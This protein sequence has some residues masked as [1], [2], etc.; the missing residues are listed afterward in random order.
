KILI[1]GD[2]LAGQPAPDTRSPRRPIWTSH[3]THHFGSSGDPHQCF[4]IFGRLCQ[5]RPPAPAPSRH[6]Y[7]RARADQQ[8]LP[9]HLRP[10]LTFAG[11]QPVPDHIAETMNVEP[12]AEV[13]SRR[14]GLRDKQTGRVEELGASYLPVAT[15]AA[16]TSNNPRWY[17]ALF[18]YEEELSGRHY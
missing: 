16:P 9:S 13:V 14:R 7:G 10:E 18:L 5:G 15:R 4:S 1:T 6:R 2:H 3:R 11:R 12:A 8:L 17:Q